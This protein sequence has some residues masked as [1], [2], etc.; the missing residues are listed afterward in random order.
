MRDSHHFELA[1]KHRLV[2]SKTLLCSNLNLTLWYASLKLMLQFGTPFQNAFAAQTGRLLLQIRRLLPRIEKFFSK[3]VE[4]FSEE[5]RV[6]THISFQ[7][8]VQLRL[9]IVCVHI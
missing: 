8:A 4:G 3:E 5:L 6:R 9:C 1:L 2:T 7:N